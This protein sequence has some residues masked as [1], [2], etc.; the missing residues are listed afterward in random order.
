[1]KIAVDFDGTLEDPNIKELVK[2]IISLKHD[3]QIVTTR[4][5]ESHKHLYPF[6]NHMIKSE[7][8]AKQIE[9][10]HEDIYNVSSELRIPFHFTNMIYKREFLIKNNFDVL[11]DDNLE[12]Q[13]KLHGSKIKFISCRHGSKELEKFVDELKNSNCS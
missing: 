6:Y 3:V 11:I 1:M 10:L 2:E 8:G 9:T 4:Y 13:S 7:D 5:D 12:E